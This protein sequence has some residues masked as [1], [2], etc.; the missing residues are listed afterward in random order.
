LKLPIA[1]MQRASSST[2]AVFLHIINTVARTRKTTITTTRKRIAEA[3][4]LSCVKAISKAMKTLRALKLITYRTRQKVS[5]D[6]TRTRY[7]VVTPHK[8]ALNALQ[9]K[10][11]SDTEGRQTPFSE[12]RLATQKGVKHPYSL[13]REEEAAFRVPL[14]PLPETDNSKNN[15]FLDSLKAAAKRQQQSKH[16]DGGQ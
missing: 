3:T 8:R 10:S 7:Y 1:E 12:K 4:G 16:N 5:A 9:Q 13:K 2:P 6:S 11:L 14:Q 15:A